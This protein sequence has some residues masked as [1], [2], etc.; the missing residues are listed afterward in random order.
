MKTKT[1]EIYQFDELDN[2]AKEK[3]ISDHIEFEIEFMHNSSSYYH[4]VTE[5]EAMQTPWFLGQ[6][7]YEAHKNDI[8]GDIK[9][10]E[11]EFLA[12]GSIS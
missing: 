8:I 4:C 1:I 10:N 5:M 7:I 6:V 2:D 9:C 12:D 3:A 11:Y